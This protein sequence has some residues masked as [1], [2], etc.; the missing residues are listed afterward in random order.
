MTVIVAKVRLLRVF[1]HLMVSYQRLQMKFPTLERDSVFR[2]HYHINLTGELFRGVVVASKR[3]VHPVIKYPIS[4]GEYCYA[5]EQ[6]RTTKRGQVVYRCTRCK[7]N[8]NTISI[9]VLCMEL[10]TLCVQMV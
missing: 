8:G 4:G 7:K 6:V 5:F 3:G 2:R 1:R 9:A 10:F